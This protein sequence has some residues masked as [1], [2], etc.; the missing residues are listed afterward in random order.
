V[1]GTKAVRSGGYAGQVTAAAPQ[2]DAD[3][4]GDVERAVARHLRPSMTCEPH[5]DESA[6]VDS[7][8]EVVTARLGRC[9]GCR[10]RMEGGETD[11]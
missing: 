6:I 3:L 10:A 5:P 11:V 7:V 4:R 2:R 1:N 9:R 8:M